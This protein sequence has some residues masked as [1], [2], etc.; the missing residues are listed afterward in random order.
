MTRHY[1]EWGISKTLDSIF[2]A[3]VQGWQR[4][5]RGAA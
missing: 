4:R 5:R 2:A 1:R 3:I